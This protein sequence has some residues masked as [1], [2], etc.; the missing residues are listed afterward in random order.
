MGEREDAE[1][2]FERVFG[3]VQKGSE[4]DA[5]K[6]E[7]MHAATQKL[8]RDSDV[9][10]I[11][12]DSDRFIFKNPIPERLP[13]EPPPAAN[14]PV[15]SSKN[16]NSSAQDAMTIALNVNVFANI[17]KPGEENKPGDLS[18]A[19]WSQATQLFVRKPVEGSSHSDGPTF[20]ISIPKEALNSGTDIFKQS[21]QGAKQN[22][23]SNNGIPYSEPTPTTKFTR[24]LHVQ[25][26][27]TLP[28]SQPLPAQIPPAPPA[29]QSSSSASGTSSQTGPSDF[30]RIVNGSEL[31]ALQ[32]KFAASSN[33]PG[34]DQNAWAPPPSA[35]PSLPAGMATQIWS[36][37]A[38]QI[39]RVA[40]QNTQRWAAAN[41]HLPPTAKAPELPVPQP[42]KI[43]Q[44]L[45]LILLLNL[46]FLL[47]SLLIV[48]FA[49]K[50]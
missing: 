12:T 49:V 9:L 8:P 34:S 21:A 15:A 41:A 29:G 39:Q 43:S 20:A 23:A 32:E 45:P 3:K 37:S 11:R 6:P 27:I 47:A 31:R 50:K 25:D 4:Q 36:A 7:P 18:N 28:Q 40:A 10:G 17:P 44:Y 46:L 13:I 30:T 38:A 2:E 26:S 14:D 5:A 19:A 33:I 35:V 16:A 1:R 22:E 42:S 24:I 48:F